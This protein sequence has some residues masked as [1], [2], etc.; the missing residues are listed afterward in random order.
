MG[1]LAVRTAVWLSALLLALSFVSP[2]VAGTILVDDASSLATTNCTIRQ[3]IWLANITANGGEWP[4]GQTPVGATTIHPLTSN[5]IDFGGNGIGACVIIPDANPGTVIDLA[6]IAGQTIAFSVGWQMDCNWYGPTALPPIASDITIEGHGVTLVGLHGDPVSGDSVRLFFVGA[7]PTR[8]ETPGYNTPGPGKLTLRNLTLRGGGQFGDVAGIGG[9]GGAGMGG[10]IFN[11]GT[12]NLIGVTLR[13]NRATGGGVFQFV[14]NSFG[15]GMSN[16]RIDYLMGMGGF[17]PLGTGDAG[18]P[19][20]ADFSLVNGRAGG[21]IP[22]GLGGRGGNNTGCCGFPGGAGGAAGNGSGGGGGGGGARTQIISGQ[23]EIFQLPGGGGSGAG[24]L[25]GTGARPGWSGDFGHNGWAD[26]ITSPNGGPVGAGDG[27]GVGGGGSG[28]L[29]QWGANFG[30][31]G[32][33]GFGG[34]GGAGGAGGQYPA[35]SIERGIHSMGGDGG[36]GGGGGGSSNPILGQTARGGYGGGN[37]FGASSGGGAGMGGAIFNHGGIVNIVN[38]T[39]MDNFVYAGAAQAGGN[40]S[41]LGAAIFNLNGQ[42]TVSYSTFAHNGV[43]IAGTIGP[44][45]CDG[46]WGDAIYSVAYNGAAVTGS[47]QARVVINNSILARDPLESSGTALAHDQPTQ[48][49]GELANIATQ[50]VAAS[51][52]NVVGESQAL[53]NA[54]SFPNF[55][56]SFFPTLAASEAT[57]IGVLI[58]LNVELVGSTDCLDAT[59]QL[60]TTDQRGLPRPATGC[61][62]GAVQRQRPLIATSAGSAVFSQAAVGAS[63]AIA[64]DSNLGVSDAE[65]SITTL[66][67]AIITLAT[68]YHG[69]QD[70]LGFTPNAATMGNIIGSAF[71]STNGRLQLTSPNALASFAQWQ[72]A[73]RAVTYTNTRQAPNPAHAGPRGI[74]F[75]IGDG[76]VASDIA[77]RSVQVNALIQLS[78]TPLPDAVVGSSY[79]ATIGAIGGSGSYAFSLTG[80]ALP[81]GITLSPAGALAGASNV[82][83]NHAFTVQA[84]DSVGSSA[85]RAYAIVV[86][87]RASATSVSVSPSTSV[88]GE[89]VTITA[90]VTGSAPIGS[91]TFSDGPTTLCAAQPLADGMAS[92]ATTALAVGM[93][94]LGASYSGDA[95]HLASIAVPVSHTVRS[96][97]VTQLSTACALTVVENTPFTLMAN[98]SGAAPS[99]SVTFFLDGA[100]PFCVDTA[101]LQ[102][103]ATCTTALHT[104]SGHTQDVVQIT[105]AYSG[106]PANVP[107]VSAALE[108]RVLNADDVVFRGPFE[109]APAGC[110]PR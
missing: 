84:I 65:P 42:V 58:P 48:V 47:H 44:E 62:V 72:A 110:A 81:A 16:I 43:G 98:I 107:S 56:Y 97:T 25:G 13:D 80:G 89:L 38:S 4:H 103:T 31:G 7:D 90:S 1:A 78:S 29:T 64:I 108:V 74:A 99:G 21:G 93:H 69:D 57:G 37:A 26:S 61:D 49:S 36:F 105:A 19:V 51:G 23:P 101:L 95:N 82:A 18:A 17:V 3:A 41:A 76:L 33:G 96:T 109:T 52:I 71:D 9:G 73:L 70:Q 68:N 91:V 30:G 27:G 11:Q 32:G 2:A 100:A 92:C 94:S 53:G 24:F 5:Y 15:G 59:G 87:P 102:Q 28:S 67:A 40:G 75:V 79:A 12:L 39:F 35:G 20:S 55:T 14:S 83:G 10:A 85:S 66:A 77:T 106:D 60:V 104:V 22:N 34:G 54:P 88:P 45:C 8:S 63:T 86:S 6:A 46:F 50:S